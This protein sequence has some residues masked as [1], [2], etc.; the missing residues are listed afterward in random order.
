MLL[1]GGCS[2]LNPRGSNNGTSIA[3]HSN[4]PCKDFAVV[5]VHNARPLVGMDTKFRG[6]FQSWRGSYFGTCG[7]R[8]AMVA[9]V[10]EFLSQ[11]WAY[12]WLASATSRHFRTG[13]QSLG[14][15]RKV[16]RPG[17]DRANN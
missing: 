4:A 3:T 17:D 1:G 15:P 16:V 5:G 12:R 8:Q 11:A 14:N 6:A 13:F 10:G 7:W 2:F 9:P